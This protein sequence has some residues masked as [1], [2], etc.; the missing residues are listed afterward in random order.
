MMLNKKSDENIEIKK[1]MK[2]SKRIEYIY[3]IFAT[4]SVQ[5][6]LNGGML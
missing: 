5:L 2:I 4:Q 1:H 6:I 3:N